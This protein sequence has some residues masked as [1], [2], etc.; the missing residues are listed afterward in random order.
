MKTKNDE[1]GVVHTIVGNADDEYQAYSSQ[2]SPIARTLALTAI[3]VIWLFAG[4]KIGNDKSPLAIL[5]SL[6]ATYSLDV[7]LALALAVL[8]TDLLQY[9]W[10][11]LAWGVYR[12]SLEQILVNDSFDQDDL[13]A[14]VRLGWAVARLLHFAQYLEYQVGRAGLE[15][16]RS[17]PMRRGYFRAQLR[18]MRDDKDSGTL[19]AATEV[20]WS[21]AIINRVTIALFL[22]KVGLLVV[23]YIFLG[24][25]LLF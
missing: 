20:P 10:G 9:V 16:G 18:K 4:A 5:H 12:W 3:A 23:C 25:F 2:V 15:D 1:V 7:A 6:E 13:S 19:A 21:P 14:R 11:S 17:W 8:L 22:C 24:H